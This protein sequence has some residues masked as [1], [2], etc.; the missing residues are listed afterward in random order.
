MEVKPSCISLIEWENPPKKMLMGFLM[1]KGFA[2]HD[3]I[4]YTDGW[5]EPLFSF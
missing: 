4:I 1:L 3:L 2:E 5:N